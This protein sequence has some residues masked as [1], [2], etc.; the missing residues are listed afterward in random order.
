MKIEDIVSYLSHARI[1]DLSKKAVPGKAEGPLDTGRRKYE[2]HPFSFPPGETMHNIELESHISTHVEAP[3]HFVPV[4][5]RRKG[6]DVTEL[7]LRT[8]FGLAVLVDCQDLKPKTAIG[9]KI[10]K[11][12]QI[13]ENDI[14]FIGKGPHERKDRCYLGKEG[15]EFLV[16]KKIKMV[17]FDDTVFPEN[18]KYAGRNLKKYFT[19]DLMLSN[20]I[21]IIEGLTNLNK[22]KRKKFL[23]FG[24]PAKLGGLEAFP[25]RAVAIEVA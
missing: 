11:G 15:A 4:R 9:R 14:V 1:T 22:L 6:K 3:S 7:D 18:P 2:I 25:I 24:F 5:H 23:F 8:F 16:E 19:H 12:C 17:G 13:E 20:S 21:P 10:L